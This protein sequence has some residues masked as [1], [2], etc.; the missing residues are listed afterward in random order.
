MSH[1]A[2]G[3]VALLTG[4]A[5]VENGTLA[6]GQIRLLETPLAVVS[7]HAVDGSTTC[8]SP[9][10][11][12][13]PS[14]PRCG[15]R[16]GF[17]IQAAG[18][19]VGFERQPVHRPAHGDAAL[20]GGWPDSARAHRRGQ[21][22]GHRHLRSP[23]VPSR[24][25]PLPHRRPVPAARGLRDAGSKAPSRSRSRPRSRCSFD[26][27]LATSGDLQPLVRLASAQG[28]AA[29]HRHLDRGRHA[30]CSPPTR[31]SASNLTYTVTVN[32]TTDLLGHVQTVAFTSTFMTP[33]TVVPVLQ[34]QSPPAGRAGAR[35]GGP[36]IT[37]HVT[38]A[39]VGTR[40]QPGGDAPRR[41]AGCGRARHRPLHSFVAGRTSPTE[42][43]PSRRSPTIGPATGATSWPASTSTRCLPPRP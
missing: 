31:R 22:L 36:S 8:P 34:L 26:E 17:Y 32:G 19:G 21:R 25:Q 10:P 11:S 20:P 29:G 24:P 5:V 12:R 7:I 2:L 28:A 18:Q 30:A 40:H 37:V 13:S 23:P 35:C 1:A 14:T 9:S 4:L 6:L 39:L 41:R 27:P 38:D 3:G 33:D 42:R 16:E 43:T 15:T